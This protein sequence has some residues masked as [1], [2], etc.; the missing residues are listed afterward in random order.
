MSRNKLYQHE[1]R[2]AVDWRGG[3]RWYALPFK[4]VTRTLDPNLGIFF[5][6]LIEISILDNQKTLREINKMESPP[7]GSMNVKERLTNLTCLIFALTIGVALVIGL[8]IYLCEGKFFR[9]CSVPRPS[10]FFQ[11]ESDG[12]KFTKVTKEIEGLREYITESSVL[13]RNYRYLAIG[14]VLLIVFASSM[15]RFLWPRFALI[16]KYVQIHFKDKKKSVT[17]VTVKE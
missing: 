15:N 5:L 7:L 17:E 16:L 10:E 1:R 8:I 3:N 12:E 13:S 14:I 9:K 6:K 11:V 2:R 4:W